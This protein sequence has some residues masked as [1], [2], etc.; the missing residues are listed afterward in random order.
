MQNLVP[1]WLPHLNEWL[2]A[3]GFLMTAYVTY[4]LHSIRK[5]FLSRARL[6]DLTKGMEKS[7]SQLSSLLNSWSDHNATLFI[8][9][10]KKVA[11]LMESAKAILNRQDAVNLR[12]SLKKI[13]SGID[14]ARISKDDGWNLYGDIQGCISSLEQVQQNLQW[15]Q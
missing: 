12:K 8:Q 9:E 5:S 4:G 10:L 2:S 3:L 1:D 7:C 6:P 13:Q 14:A 15:Q 11:A